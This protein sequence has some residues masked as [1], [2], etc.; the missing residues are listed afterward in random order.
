MKSSRVRI[1][2][3][4]FLRG[5]AILLMVI[6]HFIYDLNAFY[7]VPIQYDQGLVYYI[8]KAAATLFIIIAGISSSLSRSNIKRGIKL[9]LW[10]M[11][12]TLATAITVPGSN[13]IFGILHFLGA[14]ILL[15]PLFKRQKPLLL[16]F[17]GTVIILA[18]IALDNITISNNWLAPLGLPAEDFVSVDYYP[19]MPWFGLFLYGVAWGQILYHDKKSLFYFRPR[20]SLLSTLGKHS[21]LIYLIHQPVLLLFFYLIF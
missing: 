9:L 13:I 21:L 6:F 7:Q 11:V 16:L 18:G 3:L 17:E 4:D 10:G 20:Y 8:G 15:Y 19:L 14:S 12:I 1:W 5:V 2:E